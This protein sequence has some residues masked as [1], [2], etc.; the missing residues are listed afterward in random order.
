MEDRICTVV[1]N[2]KGKSLTVDLDGFHGQGCSAIVEAFAAMGPVLSESE[3]PEFYD[4]HNQNTLTQ[5][6]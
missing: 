5:G 3:K 4:N 2:S 6:R 1:V